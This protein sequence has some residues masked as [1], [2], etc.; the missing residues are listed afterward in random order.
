MKVQGATRCECG[1]WPPSRKIEWVDLSSWFGSATLPNA[2]GPSSC[3]P[4]SR[5]LCRRM[6][7]PL[8]EFLRPFRLQAFRTTTLGFSLGAR[9]SVRSVLG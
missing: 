8:S 9:N 7:V 6:A 5:G 4:S 3:G 1:R 2:S